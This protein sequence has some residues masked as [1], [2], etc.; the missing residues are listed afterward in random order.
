MYSTAIQVLFH[1]NKFK[2]SFESRLGRQTTRFIHMDKTLS[3]FVFVFSEI[4]VFS[5]PLDSD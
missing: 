4:V 3:S 1:V 5:I 2:W